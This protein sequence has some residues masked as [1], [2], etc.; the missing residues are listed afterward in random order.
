MVPTIC[1][2]CVA[3]FYLTECWFL[4]EVHIATAAYASIFYTSRL[5]PIDSLWSPI[6]Q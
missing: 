6:H 4:D 3:Y 5:P 1:L 2:T